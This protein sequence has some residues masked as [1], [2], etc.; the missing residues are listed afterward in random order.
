[1]PRG[2]HEIVTPTPMPIRILYR[3]ANNLT[4]AEK[5]ELRKGM[6]ADLSNARTTKLMIVFRDFY[7]YLAFY[8]RGRGFC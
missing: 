6:Q 1:M 8:P 3:I 2:L 5:E 4:V 7:M